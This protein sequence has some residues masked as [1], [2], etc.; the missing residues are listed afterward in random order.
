MHFHDQKLQKKRNWISIFSICLN[1]ILHQTIQQFQK[2][3]RVLFILVIKIEIFFFDKFVEEKERLIFRNIADSQISIKSCSKYV[4]N[5]FLY[6]FKTG[7][8]C[9]TTRLHKKVYKKKYGY[10]WIWNHEWKFIWIHLTNGRDVG[11]I[12]RNGMCKITSNQIFALIME[13]H[14]KQCLPFHFLILQFTTI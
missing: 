11:V 6:F 1:G 5:V 9:W 12:F 14:I 8:F 4:A 3:V 7:L 2:N 13:C 10:K